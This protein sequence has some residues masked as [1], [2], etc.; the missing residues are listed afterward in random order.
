MN[1]R[2]NG[3]ILLIA[4]SVPFLSGCY[5]V[6]GTHPPH[7]HDRRERHRDHER[8]VCGPGGPPPWAP[9]HGY[10]RKCQYRYY[11]RFEIYYSVSADVYYW[12]VNGTWRSGRYLPDHIQFKDGD[13]VSLELKTDKPYEHHEEI[14]E[15]HGPYDRGKGPG[16]DNDNRGRGR[17]ESPD[18]NDEERG[19]PFGRP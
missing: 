3:I 11:P 18:D 4:V 2:R 8:R 19:P 15:K 9:A 5:A 13:Y 10:R 1:V 16:N 6:I 14:R 12:E 17:G 7:D